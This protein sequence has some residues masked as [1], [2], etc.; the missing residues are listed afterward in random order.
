MLEFD[1]KLTT[2]VFNLISKLNDLITKECGVSIIAAITMRKDSDYGHVF[3]VFHPLPGDLDI[4]E[5]FTDITGN[6]NKKS[7][8]LT[9]EL[10]EIM[11]KPDENKL[12]ESNAENKTEDKN[13]D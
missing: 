1:E 3:G 5:N 4:M 2:E 12:R 11:G 10:F 7:F 8:E 6:L 13:Q 9:K